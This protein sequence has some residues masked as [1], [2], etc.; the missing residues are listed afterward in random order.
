MN[1]RQTRRADVARFRRDTRGGLLTWLVDANDPS[2]HEAPPQVVRA[3]Y[4]WCTNLPTEP[5]HCICCLSLIWDQREVGALL[6]SASP[7]AASVSINAVCNRCW[8]D[9]PLDEIE[10]AATEV[11]RGAVPNGH[12]EPLSC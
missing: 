5:R 3:S 4:Y 10:H 1:N 6:L 12:F 8:A 7:N 9:Q 11:L 2:L